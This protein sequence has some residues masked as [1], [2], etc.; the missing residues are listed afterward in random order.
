MHD[1]VRATSPLHSLQIQADIVEAL[2]E[3]F[4]DEPV[5]VVSHE[6]GKSAVILETIVSF[7]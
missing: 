6:A 4:A 2:A 5:T 3:R 7:V 1:R